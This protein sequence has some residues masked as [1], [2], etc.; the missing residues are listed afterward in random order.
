MHIETARLLIVPFTMDMAKDV[1]LNSLDENTCRFLPDEVFETVEE[2]ADTLSFLMS[3]YENGDG[4]YVYPFTDKNGSCMGYV[5]A[6]PMD[7]D[8]WEI[9]YH[10]GGKFANQGYATE[11]VRAFLPVIMQRLGIS[12]I[13]GVCL[14]ENIASLRVLEKCGFVKTFEGTGEYQG[15]TTQ[16]VKYVFTL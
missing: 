9:G 11:A 4:P 16:I 10:T 1:H 14:A 8:D 2:A 3:V 13:H 6:V 12:R 5:Q 7:D 15:R